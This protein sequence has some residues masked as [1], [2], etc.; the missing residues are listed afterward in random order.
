M[1]D[2]CLER[3]L[4]FVERFP[5][6]RDS[7]FRSESGSVSGSDSDKKLRRCKCHPGNK[8]WH[9]PVEVIKF[10]HTRSGFGTRFRL[11]KTKQNKFIS[12]KQIS[13][14]NHF[15][16]LLFCTFPP[17]LDQYILF[18]PYK[19]WAPKPLLGCQNWVTSMDGCQ[20]IV[21]G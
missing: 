5:A 20:K 6:K 1:N 4:R 14:L 2:Q 7:R 16:Q 12:M 3:S 18:W 9:P 10:W 19:K 15:Q 17:P 11:S 13:N 8:F 21:L